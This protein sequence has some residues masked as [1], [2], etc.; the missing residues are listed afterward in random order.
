MALDGINT[1]VVTGGFVYEDVDYEY[2]SNNQL[3]HFDLEESVFAADGATYP[4]VYK[5]TGTDG[6]PIWTAQTVGNRID[7]TLGVGGVTVLYDEEDHWLEFET[8]PA[9]LKRGFR[10][11]GRFKQRLRAVVEDELQVEDDGVQLVTAVYNDTIT[12][13]EDAFELGL[14]ELGRRAGTRQMTFTTMEPGLEPGQEIDITDSAQG[15]SETL[16]ISRVTERYGIEGEFGGGYVNL[17]VEAGDHNPGLDDI[18]AQNYRMATDRPPI[19]ADTAT[20]ALSQLYDDDN[21]PMWDDDNAP[22]YSVEP[23]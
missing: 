16:I 12:T 14:A 8:A 17:S 6:T 21:L 15:I 3:T 13:E 2:P 5:N 22:L 20:Q 18:I 10:V 11:V 1:V 9:D 23:L 19:T 4:I 7:N